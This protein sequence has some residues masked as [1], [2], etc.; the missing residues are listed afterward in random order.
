MKYVYI[1]ILM[2][3]KSILRLNVTYYKI[4]LIV[5]EMPTPFLIRL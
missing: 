5:K 4:T 2:N 3:D 1:P